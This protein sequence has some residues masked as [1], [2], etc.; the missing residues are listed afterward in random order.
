MFSYPTRKSFIVPV[1]FK[2]FWWDR[3]MS[4]HIQQATIGQIEELGR[5]PGYMTDL[6]ISWGV[7]RW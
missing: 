7:P 6:L 2:W 3:T 1:T 4:I 5:D